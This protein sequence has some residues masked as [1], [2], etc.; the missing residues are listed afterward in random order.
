MKS[1][2]TNPRHQGIRV[3][4]KKGKIGNV[5]KMGSFGGKF[6]KLAKTLKLNINSPTTMSI[7]ENADKTVQEFIS[8][9]RQG[10]IKSVFPAE[11]LN[12]TVKEALQSG[13]TTVRKLLTDSRFLK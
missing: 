12:S 8:T 6:M 11:H 3:N 13:N 2:I 1:R 7:L 5:A 4:L 9:H 10:N